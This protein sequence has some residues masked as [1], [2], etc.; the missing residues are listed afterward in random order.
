[1][2]ITDRVL[3]QLGPGERRLLDPLDVYFLESEDEDTRVR[4]RSSRA[5]TDV[6][7]LGELETL[8][9]PHGFLRVHRNYLVN[10]RRVREIRRRAEGDHWE[11][12][13]EPP[14]NRVLRSAATG[15]TRCGWRSVGDL[16]E[17]DVSRPGQSSP[18]DLGMGGAKHV[19]EAQPVRP[20]ARPRG[21]RRGWDSNPRAV[22]RRRFSRPVLS[23]TQ[24]P[25]RGSEPFQISRCGG[26]SPR[27]GRPATGDGPPAI[28][29]RAAGAPAR[30]S[31]PA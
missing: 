19:V 7:P 14:V 17:E 31:P 6:R 13:L 27:E 20:D 11:L 2:A 3:L 5:L 22:A 26:S 25:L 24:P 18:G 15:C 23:T 1:M 16:T 30:R 9:T 21:W 8:F 29:I 10:L 28:R 4:L 12:K